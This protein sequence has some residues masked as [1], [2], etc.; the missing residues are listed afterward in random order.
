[1]YFIFASSLR[2]Q[3]QK[4]SQVKYFANYA[5]GN[6]FLES[7]STTFHPDWQPPLIFVFFYFKITWANAQEV[8]DRSD[9]D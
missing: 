6:S 9:K 8:W 1:M 5:R 4:L 2:F 3:S 7:W